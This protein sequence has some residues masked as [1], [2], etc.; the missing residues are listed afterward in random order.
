MNMVFNSK[1]TNATLYSY[2]TSEYFDY[3]NRQYRSSMAFAPT[4]HLACTR[5]QGM[6]DQTFSQTP[7]NYRLHDVMI[8]FYP[9]GNTSFLKLSSSDSG[10]LCIECD[11]EECYE[12]DPDFNI[13]TIRPFIMSS[14]EPVIYSWKPCNVQDIMSQWQDAVL[15][16]S[17]L[18]AK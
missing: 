6:I 13:T 15:E 17:Q 2:L 10:M 14:I 3:C 12:S 8:R 5:L 9:Y 16:S 18:V 1:P 4:I 11:R 7:S